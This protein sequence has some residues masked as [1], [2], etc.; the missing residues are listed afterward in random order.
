MKPIHICVIKQRLHHKGGLEK[1]TLALIEELYALG[2][3]LT[4]ITSDTDKTFSGFSYNIP[5]ISIHLKS[6][7]KF[8]QILE[9]DIRAKNVVQKIKPDIIFGFDRTTYQTDYR[10]GNGSHLAYL[11]HRKKYESC[12]KNCL[13]YCNP[14]HWVILSQE[15]KMLQ[16]PLLRHL[17]VNSHMVKNEFENLYPLKREKIHVVHNGINFEDKPA[18]STSF[19]KKIQEQKQALGFS[20]EKTLFLF[21][22]HGW[23]RKG[24][25]E[26]LVALSF[27]KVKNWQLVV[28]GSDR[29]AIFY[30]RL[31]HKLHIENNVTFFPFQN[32]LYSI[33]EACDV[34]VCPSHYD[35]FANIVLEGLIQG[36]FVIT[37]SHNGAKE[38]LTKETGIVI[39]EIRDPIEFSQKLYQAIGYRKTTSSITRSQASIEHLEMR[40][41][42]QKIIQISLSHV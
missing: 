31:V 2:H 27:L 37:S 28:C 35:P 34:L 42:L 24:L 5:I 4:V 39:D 10:A 30:H 19:L 40:Q 8:L 7:F 6:P 36:L 32:N 14:L 11:H 38:I 21:A 26:L 20:E 23:K 16:S 22:A 15:K 25:Q 18:P 33:M 12:F 1:V 17:F 3:L 29:K 9:F 13:L 41:Q